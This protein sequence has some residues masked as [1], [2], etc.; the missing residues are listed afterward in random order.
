MPLKPIVPQCMPS[1]SDDDDN[2]S[3]GYDKENKNGM[4]RW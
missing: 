3:S 1:D 4:M 2:N